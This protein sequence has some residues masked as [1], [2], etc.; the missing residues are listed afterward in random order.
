MGRVPIWCELES[1]Q[2]RRS[3]GR[4]VWARGEDARRPDGGRR[5]RAVVCARR[6]ACRGGGGRRKHG[7]VRGR[8]RGARWECEEMR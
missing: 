7:R 3:D 1:A 2:G 6:G 5:W 4:V 8:G